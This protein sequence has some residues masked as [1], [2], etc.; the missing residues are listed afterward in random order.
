MHRTLSAARK[1]AGP[2]LGVLAVALAGGADGGAGLDLDGLVA[3]GRRLAM[4]AAQWYETTPPSDRI[5]WGGLAAASALGLWVL[6]ERSLRL[7]R[8]RILPTEFEPR[9]LDRL[10][11]GKLDRGKA[12]D[13]CELNP[14]PASRLALAAVRR[15]GRPTPDLER[16]VTLALR[17]ETEHL[18]RNVGTLRRVAALTPLIGLLGTLVATGRALSTVGTEAVGPAWGPAMASALSPL[19][20]GVAIAVL[21]LIAYDGL[22]GR[23]EKLAGALDRIGAETV[24]AIVMSP[25][26]RAVP[27]PTGQART[28]HQIRLEIPDPSA[29]HSGAEDDFR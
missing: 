2:A 4:S 14:S 11:D 8:K 18:R 24:D 16:A 10:R 26:P 12:L 28:P 20:A 6:A 7:R 25:E 29:H 9:F 15:W 17:V 19:T 27:H 1:T 13:F 23:V 5:A 3:Q 22:A 21:A